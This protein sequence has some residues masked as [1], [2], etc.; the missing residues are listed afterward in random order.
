EDGGRADGCGTVRM[1]RDAGRRDVSDRR[2][3]GRAPG[4][5]PPGPGAARRQPQQPPPQQPPPPPPAAGAGAAEVPP[6]ATVD[7][8][9]TVSSWPAGQA[10]GAEDSAM[11]RLSSKVSPQVRQRYS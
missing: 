3:G 5:A 10:A 7:S 11:G 8:S 2:L 4:G 1:R 6:T 9:L